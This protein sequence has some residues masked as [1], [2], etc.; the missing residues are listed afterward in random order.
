MC[1]RIYL[2]GL[3][4]AVPMG[5]ALGDDV[6]LYDTHYEG[7]RKRMEAELFDGE[8]FIQKIEQKNLRAKNPAEFRNYGENYSR[9]TRVARERRPQTQ[10]GAGLGRAHH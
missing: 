3:H 4:A 5:T 8:Y 7:G 2:G 1:T 6:S 10:A 9:N